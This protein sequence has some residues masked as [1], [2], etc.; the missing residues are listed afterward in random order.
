[1]FTLRSGAVEVY[2]C[3]P[4]D[5]ENF[6]KI[7]L[8]AID[9]GESCFSPV[10]MLSPLEFLFFATTDSEIEETDL[11]TAVPEDFSAQAATWFYKLTELPWIRY[12][13]GMNDEMVSRWDARTVFVDEGGGPVE[14]PF[15]A[16][17]SHQEILSMLVGA[18][19]KSREQRVTFKTTKRVAQREKTMSEA[20]SNLTRMEFA[21]A[22]DEEILSATADDP[23]RFAVTAVARHFRMETDSIFLPA[24]IA[25]KMDAVTKM[26]RLI[27][28]ANMQVRLVSLPDD[29][30]R[31]DS[32]VILGYREGK[33]GKAEKE[34][35]KGEERELVALLPKGSKRYVMKSARYPNG[36]R[37]D[38]KT[39]ATIQ[40]DAF[41]CY[42]GLPA[43][44]LGIA[45]M[46]R[47][48]LRHSLKVD[49]QMVWFFSM[50]SG[51]LPLI[52]PLITENIFRDV[53]P[54]N[55]R[56]ALGT[57]TQVM[58]VSGFATVIV[59]FAR[60]IAFLRIKNHA[61]ITLE[62]ALWSR[63]LSLPARFFR[64]YEIGNLVGRMQG[65]GALSDLFGEN[66]LSGLFNMIFSFWSLILMFYYS[67]RLT[68]TAM[69]VW[70]VYLSINTCLYRKIVVAQRAKVGASN[71]ASAKTIQVL[72]GLSKFR[73]QGREESAFRLWSKAFGDE[74]KWNLK[75]RWYTNYA[76]ILNSV[77]PTI[78]TMIVYYMSTQSTAQGANGAPAMDYAQFMGF[79]AAFT[80]F[81]ATLVGLVPL[82]SNI[83]SAAPFLENIKPILE[84]V[85][86][87][88][89]DKMDV[90]ELSGQIEARNVQFSYAPDSPM[91]L[92]GISFFIRAGEAVAVVG[93]SGC[94]KST[95]V[96]VLLGF[97]KPVQGAILFDGQDFSTLNVTSVRSQMGVVLQ[98][99]QL[100]SGDIFTNIVGSSPLT[101]DDAWEAARMVGL[102]RDIE[103]M[104]MG[105]NTMIS[106]GAGNISGGQRQRILLARSIV[107]R[108][109]ILILDEATSALDNVTQAL[110]TENLKKL[111]ATRIILAH[112]L[113]TIRDADRIFVIHEG[114][115]AEE[116]SFDSLMK[117]GGLFARLARRQME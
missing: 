93:P 40:K 102:D 8:T 77:Q 39:A 69:V 18:Q 51:L 82:V 81:N 28:K 7:F 47:F 11:G 52:L 90:G 70:V 92:K 53:I 80:G 60:S 68:M 29:W 105:M 19:F 38:K 1:M 76:G 97:E 15:E 46:L 49:W 26:R 110:V 42:A 107:T 113:S 75:T 50:V 62:S 20:I 109:K 91:V 23:I 22:S 66:L 13:V 104:P 30:Y 43:R 117:A 2:A 73:M 84:E 111:R 17:S 44:S 16:F 37:V 108:P 56:Q 32:G 94:G 27:K 41:L 88:T 112:R 85:P 98:G 99:G 3:T 116:G 59:G 45:D 95:L 100:L 4:A 5:A 74:W 83:F 9:S 72:S 86:E 67:A 63:L 101:V 58:L 71:T 114:T 55:D 10:E 78:L 36:R 103:N 21:G 106:E 61:G 89:E 87:V 54:I 24:E 6:H 35:E 33:E 34:G 115:I 79:Q 96:R 64:K 31:S 25:A 48:V 12:L 65:V 57:L 14:S